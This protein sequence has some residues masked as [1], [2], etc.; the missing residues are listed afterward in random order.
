MV[1]EQNPEQLSPK[2]GLTD[3]LVGKA[4]VEARVLGYILLLLIGLTLSAFILQYSQSQYAIAL[5]NYR[6]NAQAEASDTADSIQ[7]IF[8]HIYQN[9]RTISY[10]PSIR[11][12]ERHGKN[13]DAEDRK[14]VV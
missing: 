7:N 11:G 1:N 2:T 3:G 14:S 10:L 13:L 4:F 9:I 8:N 6:R 12:I 5:E